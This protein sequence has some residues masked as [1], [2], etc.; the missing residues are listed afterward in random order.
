MTADDIT[1]FERSLIR[2]ALGL[3]NR[4]GRSYR[5]YFCAT[6]GT[7]QEAAWRRLAEAGLALWSARAG[8]GATNFYPTRAAALVCLEPGEDLDP[9]DFREDEE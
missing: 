2:H 1:I 5:R 3:P 9:E 7:R 6:N 4:H 8:L